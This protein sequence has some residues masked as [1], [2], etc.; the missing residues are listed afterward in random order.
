MDH[1]SNMTNMVDQVQ[2]KMEVVG[3]VMDIDNTDKALVFRQDHMFVAFTQCRHEVVPQTIVGIVV[4]WVQV[5]G[6]EHSQNQVAP[7]VDQGLLDMVSHYR[8]L[9]KWMDQQEYLKDQMKQVIPR[10]VTVSKFVMKAPWSV[11]VG[12]LKK[13]L[14]P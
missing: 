11:Q 3:L 4:V 7:E 14:E 13:E 6:M 5:I 8:D 10:I 1:S 9:Q 12:L 2:P